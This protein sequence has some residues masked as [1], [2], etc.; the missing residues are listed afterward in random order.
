MHRKI[1]IATRDLFD[2]YGVGLGSLPVGFL[3]WIFR[4]GG[5]APPLVQAAGVPGNE[6]YFSLDDIKMGFDHSG[7]DC[8]Y[9]F[10]HHCQLESHFRCRR[11]MGIYDWPLGARGDFRLQGMAVEEGRR[12]GQG[13]L[14]TNAPG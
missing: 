10:Q 4:Q 2:G 6:L 9:R 11:A 8:A 7:W 13:V 14:E 1:R 12:A 3:L 5:N